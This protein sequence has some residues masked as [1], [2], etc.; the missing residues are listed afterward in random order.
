VTKQAL[1]LIDLQQDYF[2]GGAYPLVHPDPAL[3][4]ARKVLDAFRSRKLPVMH[5]RHESIR[6]GATFFLPGTPGAEIHPLVA[7]EGNEPVLTK[8][9]PNAFRGT[10]LSEWLA[11]G[12]IRHLVIVGMMT[13][14][15]VDSTVRAAFDEGYRVTVLGDATATRPIDPVPAEWVQQAF[16]GSWQGTFADV[17]TTERFL[18]TLR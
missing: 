14:M 13:H 8:H 7:P 6:P 15:C 5:I 16:L 11:E 4:E 1:I 18:A 2:E 9:Y 17:I 3:S 12:A 10:A